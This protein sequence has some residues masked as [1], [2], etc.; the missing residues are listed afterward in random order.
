MKYISWAN[1]LVTWISTLT[2]QLAKKALLM[3]HIYCFFSGHFP[4]NF[5]LFSEDIN[6][7]T[8]TFEH[9]NFFF[10]EFIRCCRLMIVY[11]LYF[12]LTVQFFWHSQTLPSYGLGSNRFFFV[13][14]SCCLTFMTFANKPLTSHKKPH[15]CCLNIYSALSDSLDLNK[16]L[17]VLHNLALELMHRIGERQH[18]ITKKPTYNI[19]FCHFCCCCFSALLKVI[20]VVALWPISLIDSIWEKI[21]N[22]F[23]IEANKVIG[24]SKR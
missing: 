3:C 10:F 2:F 15:F 22:S 24:H 12:L 9:L 21:V 13:V 16:K 4:S 17:T 6:I 20:F 8:S 5:W 14:S 7:K 18:H 11:N 1:R 23:L 19:P